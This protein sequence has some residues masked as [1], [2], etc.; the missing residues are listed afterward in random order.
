[1]S[2]RLKALTTTMAAW[3]V[4]CLAMY[5]VFGLIIGQLVVTAYTAWFG[6]IHQSYG[7]FERLSTYLGFAVITSTATTISLWLFARLLHRPMKWKLSGMTFVSWEVAVVAVLI[8]SYEVGF[9]Y[10]IHQ[11]DWALF[12]PQENLY[13][14]RNLIL[15]RIIA[16]LL[17]T[18]PVSCLTLWIYGRRTE[19][20]TSEDRVRTPACGKSK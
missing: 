3:Q 6:D 5:F 8:C 20:A 7:R 12:G 1:M 16:W 18:I 9:A 2:I 13:S 15:H 19:V 17:C 11:F 10:R 14:F 4:T